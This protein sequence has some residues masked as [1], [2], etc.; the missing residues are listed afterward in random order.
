MSAEFDAR[1]EFAQFRRPPVVAGDPDYDAARRVWNGYHDLSPA[2]ILR[3]SSSAEIAAGIR[4]ARER[5]LPLAVRGGGHSFP[6]YGSC[7]FSL[8]S[9]SAA[10]RCAAW[11]R[12][13]A[14][15]CP[16]WSSRA[17]ERS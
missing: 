2:A 14:T 10:T 15:R 9:C 3:C 1:L 4:S 13:A 16:S 6:G 17:T 12:A 7:S 5:D 11:V 8:S